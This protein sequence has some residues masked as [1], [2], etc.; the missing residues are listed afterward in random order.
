MLS[1]I[2]TMLG[3]VKFVFWLLF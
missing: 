1:L 2:C 3:C